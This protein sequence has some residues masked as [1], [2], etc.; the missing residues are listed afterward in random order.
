[1]SKIVLT[2]NAGSSSLKFSCFSS[3]DSPFNETLLFSGSVTGVGISNNG[4]FS[5]CDSQK[6]H[7]VAP[8]ITEILNLDKACKLVFEWI[9]SY[10]LQNSLKLQVVGHRVVFGGT[11]YS[12]PQL[13]DDPLIEALESLSSFAPQH[14][15][16]ALRSIALARLTF[17]SCV[18]HIACFD[19]AFHRTIPTI[20]STYPVP[21]VYRD[22]G[23][24]KYGFH[25][26][27]YE[28]LTTAISVDQ[29]GRVILAH[30]GHGCSLAAVRDGVCI[31]TTMGFS[32]CGG[33][34]MSTRCGDVDP[35]VVLFLLECGQAISGSS[36]ETLAADLKVLLNTQC[37]LVALSEVGDDMRDIEAAVAHGQDRAGSRENSFQRATFALD[38]FVHHLTKHLSGLVGVMG[39]L[40]GLVFSAGIG[41]NSSVVRSMVCHRLQYLGV[42]LDE[43][44]NKVHGE[45]TGGVISSERSSVGV[46][47]VKTNEELIIARHARE[48]ANSVL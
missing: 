11:T 33:F 5:V 46:R 26:L 15:P 23:L 25:G 16:Q 7:I 38:Y 9:A 31:D 21:Q 14:M 8:Q 3:G 29:S 10:I 1:M 20:A 18:K 19:T 32:P 34:P 24:Q 35:E 13:I 39:G 4:K 30:L 2:L 17:S 45:H 22:L 40:D 44:R 47:V 36:T 42:V 48:M 37:G 28:Y 43:T 27:S 12:S 41:E 6:N